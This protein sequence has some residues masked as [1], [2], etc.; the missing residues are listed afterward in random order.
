M[1]AKTVVVLAAGGLV[2]VWW[3]RRSQAMRHLSDRMMVGFLERYSHFEVGSTN[4]PYRI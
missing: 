4:R 3:A 2:G 1:L